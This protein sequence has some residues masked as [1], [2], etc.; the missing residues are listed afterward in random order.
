MNVPFMPS[1][2]FLYGGQARIRTLEADGSRFT[3]CPLCPLGY[4]P[5]QQ[6]NRLA[7]PSCINTIKG[8]RKAGI[9]DKAQFFLRNRQK[10][11]SRVFPFKNRKGRPH[12]TEHYIETPGTRQETKS[13]ARAA[14]NGHNIAT[15]LHS[16]LNGFCLLA[17]RR[18]LA[19]RG[20]VVL[21]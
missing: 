20:D 21:G 12:Q 16:R 13:K 6:L 7:V 15:V 5:F 3:V 1:H 18:D 9:Q 2:T 17:I 8:K 19:T 11:A 4:L 10:R 14:A